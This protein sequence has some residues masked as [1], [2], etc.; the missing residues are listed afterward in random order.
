MI[1]RIAEV[2]GDTSK[3]VNSSR[4][5]NLASEIALVSGGAAAAPAGLGELFAFSFLLCTSNS[6]LSGLTLLRR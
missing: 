4:I 1:I 3:I 2:K 5:P 6:E